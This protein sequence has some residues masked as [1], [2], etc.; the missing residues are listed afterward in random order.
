MGALRGSLSYLRFLVEGDVAK[1][2]GSTYEKALEARRFMPLTPTAETLESAGFVP[3]ESPFD[4]EAPLTREVFLF[5]EI[6][7]VTYREDAY[8]IPR[9]LL[10]RETKKRIDEI[11]KKEKRDPETVG[12][13]FVKAVEQ[14]V[15]V[16]LK[17]RTIP[18]S[19]LVDVIWEPAR[20]EAR[21]FARGTIATERVAALFER[22]FQVRME[23]A[24]YAARA[25]TIDIGSRAQ[26]VLEKLS[27]GWLFPEAI[28]RDVTVPG[29]GDESAEKS[30]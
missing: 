30:A 24:T 20:N 28:G 4:D 7:A 2:P 17:A 29:E 1:N 23:L 12:K 13:A 27:P 21:V 3:L 9:P 11:I 5:G 8:R 10:Q 19:K 25:F 18:R 14:S 22:T 16:E 26:G 15:L 6:I